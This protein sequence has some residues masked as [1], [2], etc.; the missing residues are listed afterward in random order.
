MREYSIGI[1]QDLDPILLPEDI[2][3]L[4]RAGRPFLLSRNQV[5]YRQ[6]EAASH[7]YLLRTGLVQSFLINSLG[8]EALLRIHLPGSILGLTTL[9]TVPIRD[10]SAKAAEPSE[11]CMI[12]RDDFLALVR[13]EM[14][15]GVRLIRLLVDR[16]RDFHSRVGDLQAQSVEQRLARV[17]LS[18]C[19]RDPSGMTPDPM[20]GI[21]LSH[22]DLAH[23]VNSRRQTITGI[24]GRFAEAG[25]IA[26]RGRRILLTGIEGL[27]KLTAP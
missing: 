20:A 3:H 9:A 7:V 10:A 6:G 24:L 17:L 5:L 12:D 1:E 2:K 18:I 16:M 22:Q 26:K 8:H 19:R 15:I 11:V 23:L 21:S 4:V 14:E 13:S 27:R 25:Y